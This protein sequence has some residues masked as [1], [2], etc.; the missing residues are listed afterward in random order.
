MSVGG[1]AQYK[2]QQGKTANMGSKI[3]LVLYEW[4]HI[5]CRIECMSELIFQNFP[6]LNQ[7]C[8]NLRNL[9]KVRCYCSTFGPKWGRWDDTVIRFPAGN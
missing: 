5:K 9:G 1:G 4:S 3:S 8:F 7:T 2:A 6:N